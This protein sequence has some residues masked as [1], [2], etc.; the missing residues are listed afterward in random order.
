MV[1]DEQ[2]QVGFED[3]FFHVLTRCGLFGLHQ[4]FELFFFQLFHGFSKDALI[5][6]KAQVV[7]EPTLFCT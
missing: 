4:V 5:H 1:W 3:G 6:V 2:A 7:D